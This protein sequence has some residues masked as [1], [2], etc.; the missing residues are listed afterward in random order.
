MLVLRVSR[1]GQHFNTVGGQQEGHLICK[2]KL[3][4]AM[5]AWLSVWGEMQICI[6]PADATATHCLLL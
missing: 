1:V 5:L 6:F 4:G 2:K 3:S